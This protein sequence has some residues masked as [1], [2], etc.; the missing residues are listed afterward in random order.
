MNISENIFGYIYEIKSVFV[1]RSAFDIDFLTFIRSRK[2]SHHQKHFEKFDVVP[3]KL[4][5]STTL[6][7]E[8]YKS[9]SEKTGGEAGKIPPTPI[10][11]KSREA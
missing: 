1:A 5:N 11:P 6:H 2:L 10:I 8:Q 3:W 9:N 7:S 4:L